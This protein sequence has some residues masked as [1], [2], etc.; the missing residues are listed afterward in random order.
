MKL[1]VP[2]P[3]LHEILDRHPDQIMALVNRGIGPEIKGVYEHWDKLR[4]RTPPDGLS[5]ELWWAGIKMSRNGMARNIPLLDIKQR[6]FHVSLTDSMQR[7]LHY[8][9]REAAGA[10]RGANSSLEGPQ[11]YLIRSLIEEAMTSSQ[12]EGAATTR[13]VAKEMLS[14]GRPPRDHGETM[15]YNNY[16]VMKDIR[17]WHTRPFTPEAIMELHATLT[18]NTLEGDQCGRLRT[19]EDH[20]VLYDRG[21]PPTLLHTP[22]PARELPARLQRL[23]DFAN[24]VSTDEFLHPVVRA[25]AIH[26][27]IGYDHP[28]C[29]GNGRTARILFYWSMLKSGYWMTEFLSISSILRKSPGNYLRAYL[30]TE[31][32][33]RD[34]SYFI[35]QQLDVIEQ[36]I[37]GLHA[38]IARKTEE[39][40]KVD[41]LLRSAD[42]L[43]QNL[44]HRQ[45]A[46][47][48][49]AIHDPG[50]SYTVANHQTAHR[51]TYPTALN[52]LKHLEQVGLL[53]K[54]KIGKALHFRP[55]A[56]LGQLLTPET[57][58]VPAR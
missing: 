15:I 18:A 1:P 2:A 11:I 49:N 21:S 3:L 4:H 35:A 51:V 26:F 52:D 38:Y 41:K 5:S 27:Q 44:N 25:I 39:N 40:R 20:I 17:D 9:D 45:R 42:I 55:V 16:A 32:D 6:P 31:S 57:T 14:T 53:T 22:P 23:C 47:L 56:N 29:D 50:R 43:G 10:I 24:K 37:K 13:V 28:F 19:A 12:L 36:A 54:R 46:L 8:V 48:A 7:R 34:L 30:Y 33:E 58:N